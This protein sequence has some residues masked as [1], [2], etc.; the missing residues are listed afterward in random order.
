MHMVPLLLSGFI[1]PLNPAIHGIRVAYV[2]AF[3]ICVYILYMGEIFQDCDS[4]KNWS[5]FL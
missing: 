3:S 5:L 1:G 4:A 2:I